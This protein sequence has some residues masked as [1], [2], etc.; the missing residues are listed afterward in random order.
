MSHNDSD[1]SSSDDNQ[2]QIQTRITTDRLLP[3]STGNTLGLPRLTD[4][5]AKEEGEVQGASNGAK[6]T[7]KTASFAL[8]KKAATPIKPV[9]DVGRVE[10]GPR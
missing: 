4:S 6:D 3:P 2:G 1:S 8:E 9:F 5:R 10:E 7:Q